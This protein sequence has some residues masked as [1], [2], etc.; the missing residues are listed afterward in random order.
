MTVSLAAG[1]FFFDSFLPDITSSHLLYILLPLFLLLSLFGFVKNRRKSAGAYWGLLASFCFFIA[2]GYIVLEERNGI[3][4]NWSDTDTMY[5]GVVESIPEEKGKS[6]CATVNVIGYIG[7]EDSLLYRIDRNILLYWMEDSISEKIECGNEVMFYTRISEAVSDEEF[8]GFDY[9]RYLFTKGISGT[10]FVFPSDIVFR[11]SKVSSVKNS[12]LQY[13]DNIVD[14]YSGWNLAPDNLAVVSALTIGDKSELTDELKNMYS[15]AGTSHVLALSGLHIGILSAILYI[16]LWPL[17]RIR[18]GSLLQSVIVSAVLWAFAFISGLSPSVVRAVTMC[19]LYL[20]AS[21]LVENGLSGLY[22]LT[23]TAFIMLLYQPLY[24][25]DIS[26]QLSFI[27]VFSIIIFFPI[28]N[29]F[30]KTG[31][32]A[33]KYVW[34]MISVSMAAQLGTMPLILY[35]FGSFPTYFLLANLIVSPIAVCVLSLTLASIVLYGFPL[36][37]ALCVFALDFCTGFLN[38]SMNWICSLEGAKI[39]SLYVN[40]LQMVILFILI[41]SSYLWIKVKKPIWIISMLIMM[42]GIAGVE[43][44]KLLEKNTPSL[45]LAW[46][47]IYLKEGRNKMKL[48]SDYGIHSINSVNIGV[49]KTEFWRDKELIPGQQPIELDYAYFCRGFKGDLKSLSGIF[50]IRKVII[51]PSLGEYYNGLIKEQCE[52]LDIPYIEISGQ[53]SYRI[54]L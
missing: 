20:L 42:C 13:R 16:L 38:S 32:K 52:E 17:K 1:I 8:M 47:D 7:K 23:V 24:L 12:A 54:V 4:Y 39:G 11:N 53:A 49:M 29:S 30:L 6:M 21:L 51:D 37:G 22:S 14:I 43:Y 33:L 48:D 45:F 10:A 25:F 9:R 41:A 3:E 50:K 40:E 5:Y 27:A 19:S 34:G 36:V 26:F 18:N 31:N 35:Y 15:T 46:S 44:Y 2:G 28:F